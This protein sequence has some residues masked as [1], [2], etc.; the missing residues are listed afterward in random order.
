M[1]AAPG[2]ERRAEIIVGAAPALRDLV[3]GDVVVLR[4]VRFGPMP[5]PDDAIVYLTEPVRDPRA[6]RG[7]WWAEADLRDLDLADPRDRSALEAGSGE[8]APASLQP[9]Q[10]EGWFTTAV[11]W[12]DEVLAGRLRGAPVRDVVQLVRPARGRPPAADPGS[13][14]C[15]PTGHANPR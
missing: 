6:A 7:R 14:P 10:R 11:A 13:R 8:D 15:R 9:W 1:G 4:D 3:G 5:P 12:I 2:V